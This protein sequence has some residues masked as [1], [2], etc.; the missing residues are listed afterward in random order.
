MSSIIA[1]PVLRH[2]GVAAVG[3][4]TVFM[5]SQARA[6]E[7]PALECLCEALPFLDTAPT[8]NAMA[9]GPGG[10]AESPPAAVAES[11]I[12]AQRQIIAQQRA[13]IDQQNV[14]LVEPIR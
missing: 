3:L 14:M 6:H 13:L 1:P 10:I 5:P 2:V 4:S 8:R 7:A 9:S 11:E 12:D